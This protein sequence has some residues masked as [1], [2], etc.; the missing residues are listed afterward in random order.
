MEKNIQTDFHI[1]E[2]EKQQTNSDY[3]SHNEQVRNTDDK[4]HQGFKIRMLHVI[5]PLTSGSSMISAYST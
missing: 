2:K 1:E 5:F 3:R 4:N